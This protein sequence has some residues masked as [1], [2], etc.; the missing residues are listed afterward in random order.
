VIVSRLSVGK[1]AG[2]WKCGL[3]PPSPSAKLPSS[4]QAVAEG[5][6]ADDREALDPRIVQRRVE[7]GELLAEIEAP[8]ERDVQLELWLLHRN[9]DRDLAQQEQLERLRQLQK[10]RDLAFDDAVAPAD[11]GHGPD[12][13]AT[14]RSREVAVQRGEQMRRVCNRIL[15]KKQSVEMMCPQCR[16]HR[17]D[18]DGAV[19]ADDSS[20]AVE[21]KAEWQLNGWGELGRKRDHERIARYAT[22]QLRLHHAEALDRDVGRRQIERAAVFVSDMFEETAA[23]Y[24]R[25]IDGYAEAGRRLEGQRSFSKR[26]EIAPTAGKRENPKE[27]HAVHHHVHGAQ[28][29]PPGRRA[30]RRNARVICVQT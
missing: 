12:E 4:P 1:E 25:R 10:Q 17:I 7:E 21:R 8:V 20:H 27:A 14:R 16:L 29:Q 13:V 30:F 6:V 19:D 2:G 15:R 24:D 26:T 22:G 18:R 28:G 11:L 3:N 9:A 5:E 23:R